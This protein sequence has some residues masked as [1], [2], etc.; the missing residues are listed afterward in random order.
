MKRAFLSLL[1]AT[2]LS[3]PALALEAPKPGDDPNIKV[4]D[5]NPLQ[6][7]LIVGM[8]DRSTTITFGAGELI[9][10]VEFGDQSN[11]SWEGPDQKTGGDLKNNLILW[12]VR[13]GR[14]DLQVITGLQDGTERVYQFQLVAKQT[15][16]NA[17]T[18]KDLTF[19]LVYRYPADVKAAQ[20]KLWKARQAQQAQQ[21]ARDRLRI[22]F[23]YGRSNYA[24][25]ARGKPEARAIAPLRVRDNGRMT[26]FEYGPNIRPPAIETGHCDNK[27]EHLATT[28]ARNDWLVAPEVAPVWCLRS[29]GLALEVVNKAFDPIGETTGTG[30][31]SPDVQRIVVSATK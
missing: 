18:D 19:G 2:S 15:D 4:V 7:V 23:W 12:P 27:T 16:A 20:V 21:T 26:G 14:T 28:T 11:P 22:D 31:A 13:P 1:L 10:R 29:S 5:Y 30:T 25:E 3:A 24:Y 6:R 17:D 8:V 9:K